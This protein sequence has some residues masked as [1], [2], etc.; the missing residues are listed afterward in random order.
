MPALRRE[1]DLDPL[2]LAGGDVQAGDR[3][4][5]GS[6]RA[7][8]PLCLGDAAQAGDAGHAAALA[9]EE[10]HR[11]ALVDQVS[12]PPEGAGAAQHAHRRAE[13]L[14]HGRLALAELHL[15]D[16][17]A[18]LDDRAGDGRRRGQECAREGGCE[19][20]PADHGRRGYNSPGPSR[21]AGVI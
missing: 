6:G 15:A 5:A 10:A 21:T 4:R 2:D 12:A 3:A 20:R 16:A 7:D 8:A 14:A 17:G 13:R 11:E 18:R 1:R 9:A 19:G